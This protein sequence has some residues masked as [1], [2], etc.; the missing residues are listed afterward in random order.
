[1]PSLVLSINF[2]RYHKQINKL[3]Y[4]NEATEKALNF[5]PVTVS[6]VQ[7]K[8][9]YTDALVVKKL[10]KDGKKLDANND[11]VAITTCTNASVCADESKPIICNTDYIY[12]PSTTPNPTC[13]QTCS[14]KLARGAVSTADKSFCNRKCDSNMTKCEGITAAET[15]DNFNNNK[16]NSGF[17]RYGYKCLNQNLSK[18]SMFFLI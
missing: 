11:C 9:T 10:C 5:T 4:Y 12:D 3:P 14:N 2:D 13:V 17:D 16:C 18:K 7:T 15:K 6:N 8:L 1:M